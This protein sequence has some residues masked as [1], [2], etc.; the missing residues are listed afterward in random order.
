MEDVI[1]SS[2]GGRVG[3]LGAEGKRQRLC[4][5]G[6]GCGCKKLGHCVTFNCLDGEGWVVQGFV[7]AIPEGPSRVGVSWAG[8][9]WCREMW[10]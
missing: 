1:V 4:L 7:S 3:R 8:G 5:W 6:G 9:V 10:W 2:G